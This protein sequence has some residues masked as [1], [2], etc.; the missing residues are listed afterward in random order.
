MSGNNTFYRIQLE[1]GVRIRP[2]TDSGIAE[3]IIQAN[4]HYVSER[5][6]DQKTI[7]YTKRYDSVELFS[8]NDETDYQQ[9]LCIIS[10]IELQTSRCVDN[11]VVICKYRVLVENSNAHILPYTEL[12]YDIE[13]RKLPFTICRIEDVN[14]PLCVIPRNEFLQSQYLNPIYANIAILVQ[15]K[16]WALNL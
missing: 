8:D 12:S 16:M 5:G 13:R 6:N 15:I 3:C 2:S 10:I 14:R 4:S 1:K 7:L 11:L 9:V